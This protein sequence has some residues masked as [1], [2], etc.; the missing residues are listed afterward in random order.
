V[1]T[2]V[3]SR[4]LTLVTRFTALVSAMLA[5]VLPGACAAAAISAASAD[6]RLSLRAEAGRIL[7]TSLAEVRPGVAAGHEWIGPRAELPLV[8]TA[9]VNGRV[10]PLHWRLARSTRGTLT[11]LCDE[12]ALELRSS[13]A[14]HPG[15]GPVEHAIRIVNRGASTVLLPPQPT[16]VLVTH[17]AAGHTQR[18]V[19][20]PKG[21]GTPGAEGARAD[22]V[23]AGYAADLFSTPYADS[24]QDLIPWISVEDVE[25]GRGW[26]AGIESSGCVLMALRSGSSD[27]L[28][29]TLGPDTREPG[30]TRLAPGEAYDA[31]TVFVGCYRGSLDD[32]SNR[33][34]RWVERCVR[35][36][37]HDRRYP[38]LVSNSWGSGT[39]VDDS[40]ARR[41][42]DDAADLGLEMFH[43]DAG[44]YR[45]VG[46]WR[47]DPRKF[48]AGLGATADYAHARGLRFG[49]WVGWAQGGD[50]R[51]SSGSG[52]ALSVFDPAMR[53]WFTREY[54][55]GWKA[56]PFTGAEVCLGD[57]RAVAWCLAL[58]RAIVARDRLDMLEH[59][60]PV[61][62]KACARTDH[63][64]TAAPGDVAYRAARGYAAI[65][66]TLRAEHP[67]LLFEDCVNGGHMVD[68]AALRRAHYVSITD[69]Y[70]PLSNR[71]AF[72]DA[73]YALPAAMCECYVESHPG[74]SLATFRSMLRSGMMGWC[75]LMLDTRQ[76]T[77]TQRV[78]ARRQFEIYK[79]VLR[80]LI[81]TANVYH[82]S[83]RPDGVHWDG[84]QYADPTRSRGVLYAFRGTTAEGSH[85]FRLR[86]LAPRAR[87][88]VTSEDGGVPAHTAT[89]R[90][91]MERGLV[92]RLG[93]PGSSDLVFLRRIPVRR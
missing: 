51:D 78:A 38:L 30:D 90:E 72:H 5:L 64:H 82:V 21:A 65:Y 77:P 57:P 1:K 11:L 91:L 60:Q 39:A 45:A 49:L 52:E 84:I 37:V 85:V 86:G 62:A 68:Y 81:N 71:R 22:T 48:P 53:D 70:D 55:P 40:L 66:D 54:T 76:W 13:L 23:C 69:T 56:Q 41:M 29:T 34:R 17:V 63:L 12:P 43:V 88:V 92:L 44:W 67:D 35:P 89:G 33:L 4:S 74:G 2:S 24:P 16:L 79:R 87:Y 73:V 47:P 59:D 9:T 25:G 6:T 26:Y 46:D 42:I 80:P 31:P 27:T 50:R 20:V 3:E 75:T 10:V 58:L 36:A 28:R 93:E 32:G 61:I 18:V 7:I 14:A 19:R 8:A 15:A 83:A